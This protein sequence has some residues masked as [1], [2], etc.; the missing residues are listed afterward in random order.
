MRSELPT[1]CDRSNTVEERYTKN[2]KRQ[3]QQLKVASSVSSPV[4]STVSIKGISIWKTKRVP[5]PGA[6]Q[7]VD[8]PQSRGKFS[9]KVSYRIT[10]EESRR[11]LKVKPVEL[12]GRNA[13][14]G[15]RGS[16]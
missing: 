2:V 8:S 11:V 4:S 3:Q 5:R 13:L 16:T 1:V 7:E 10:R 15:V 6:S 12:L 14:V 9:R